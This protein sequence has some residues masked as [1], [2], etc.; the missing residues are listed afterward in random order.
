VADRILGTAALQI[1]ADLHVP[2]LR[3]KLKHSV[4]GRRQ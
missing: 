3:W 4:M 1:P 2:G